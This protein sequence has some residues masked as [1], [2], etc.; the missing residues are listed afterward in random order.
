VIFILKEKSLWQLKRILQIMQHFYLSDDTIVALSTPAGVGAIGVIRI[1]G[2]KAIDIV[3]PLFFNKKSELKDLKNAAPNTIHFG[4]IKQQ[5]SIIDEVLI[6]LFKAPHSYTGEDTLEI[7]CH[8]SPY[9]LQKVLSIIMSQGA[10]PAEP[11]EFT[12]R[13]FK[14]KKLDL[15]QAEAV[16]DLIHSNSEAS[17]QLAMEQLRGDFSKKIKG[18][19]AQL[20]QFS[21]LIE[22]EL[23][24]SEEDV[25]FADRTALVHL[26]H[27]IKNITAK[28]IASFDLGNALKNGVPVTI[29]GRP[30]SGKSTL[31]NA[32]LEDDRA[33]VSEIAGT[34]RDTIEDQLVIEGIVFRFIDT[35]GIRKTK[36]VIEA[37]GVSKAYESVAKSA[38]IIHL[39]DSN[40]IDESDFIAQEK[41]IFDR[42]NKA[43]ILHVMNKA[44]IAKP[45]S[46]HEKHSILKIAAKENKGINELKKALIKI[47]QSK[48]IGA[49][50]TIV[51][52]ARHSNALIRADESLLRV[53]EGL[54]SNTTLELVASDLRLA[55]NALA[56]ITG[57]ITHE[58][59]LTSIFTQFCIGK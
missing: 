9:I 27:D 32:L 43:A 21:S 24:F 10:R 31:L 38:I 4:I 56:E 12:F 55:L 15:S 20:L 1:S 41:N 2:S 34:T 49:N 30:N 29:I 58:D 6:S 57:E 36:D 7:S 28:L 17:Q 44:D 37:I 13:A 52:N 14:N 46:W 19:R 45:N 3:Q 11:G 40:E 53:L 5:E 16:N 51:V 8:G 25:E 18:L 35:A 22:L 39:F 54:K 48:N 33:I 26:I 47:I 59:T 42:N 50:E 23:D